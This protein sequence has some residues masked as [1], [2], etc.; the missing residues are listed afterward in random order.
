MRATSAA[1]TVRTL[2]AAIPDHRLR[3]LVVEFFLAAVQA[4]AAE[5]P[6][7][8][9]APVPGNGRRRHRSRDKARAH[10]S[11]A[12]RDAELAKRRERGKS[13]SVMVARREARAERAL[14]GDCA[15]AWDCRGR[16]AGGAA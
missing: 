3:D 2:I 9:P 11:R 10:W 5:T 14:A 16:R 15:G 7:S 1:S 4:L 13:A 8:A 6:A 12:R